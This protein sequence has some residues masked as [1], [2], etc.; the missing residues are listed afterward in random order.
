MLNSLHVK[1][2]VFFVLPLMEMWGIAA[3]AAGHVTRPRRKTRRRRIPA[4]HSSPACRAATR[5]VCVS[6]RPTSWSGSG[7]SGSALSSGAWTEPS[8]SSSGEWTRG[9]V[10]APASPPRSR[11]TLGR[12]FSPLHAFELKNVFIVRDLKTCNFL[13]LISSPR[14]LRRFE[15]ELFK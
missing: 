2:K 7:A 12:F 11:R 15:A 9:E 13:L 5:S 4:V 6:T 10:S 14:A 1:P 8:C 3:A